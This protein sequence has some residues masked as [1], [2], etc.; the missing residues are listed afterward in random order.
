MTLN[1]RVKG[2]LIELFLVLRLRVAA[3]LTLC[4]TTTNLP[5]YLKQIWIQVE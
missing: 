4:E 1:K 3:L 2:E 5:E